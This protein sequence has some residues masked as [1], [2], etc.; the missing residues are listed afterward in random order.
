MLRTV[1]V[2]KL[3]IDKHFKIVGLMKNSKLKHEM[4]C[5][6]YVLVCGT[7]EY[8]IESIIRG[9]LKHNINK[10]KHVYPGKK[11]VD[12]VLDTFYNNAE[13]NLYNNHTIDYDRIC[14]L[15]KSLAGDKIATSLKASVLAASPPGVNMT[16]S[17]L[18]RVSLL[19]HLLAH[20]HNTT[21]ELSPNISE[22]ESDFNTIY[23]DLI[24]NLDKLL[25]RR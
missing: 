14:N 8:M 13:L 18:K 1:Y 22:L 17:A 9:W 4:M 12:G 20:G 3:Y 24:E 19:R 23:T 2:R 6:S 16:A 21:L 15:V 25:A 11:H 10:H 5:N 7:I